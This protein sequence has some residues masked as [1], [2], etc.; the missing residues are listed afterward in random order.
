MKSTQCPGALTPRE[1]FRLEIEQEMRLHTCALCGRR[2][3]YAT[4]DGSEGWKPEVHDKPLPRKTA[5]PSARKTRKS[6]DI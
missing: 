5:A 1:I 6:I 2:N 3:L 4:R